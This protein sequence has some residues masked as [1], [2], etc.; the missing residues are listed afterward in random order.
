M[1]P[2]RRRLRGDRGEITIVWVLLAAALLAAVALIYDGGTILAARRETNNIARQAA[3]AGA[4][5]LDET[6]LRAGGRL[7]D[8]GAAH[9]AASSFLASYDLTAQEITVEGDRIT[10]TIEAT[11]HT[12][13]LAPLGISSRTVTATESAQ[14]IRGSSP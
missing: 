6:S 2:L 12:P 8:P 1:T 11:A 10:V 4:Q 14:P 9:A 3:R 5:A 7:L 13:L